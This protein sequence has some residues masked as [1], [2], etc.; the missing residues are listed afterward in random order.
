[1]QHQIQVPHG[2]ITISQIEDE[3]DQLTE[4]S[5][6]KELVAHVGLQMEESGVSGISGPDLF[7]CPEQMVE[8]YNGIMCLAAFAESGWDVFNELGWL[9]FQAEYYQKMYEDALAKEKSE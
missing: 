6:S 2:T 3:E 5:I 9:K 7:F 4:I 8:N 1:M